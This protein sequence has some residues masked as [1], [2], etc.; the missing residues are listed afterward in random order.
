MY[1]KWSIIDYNRI[2][3]WALLKVNNHPKSKTQ[4]S[5]LP[6]RAR[7]QISVYSHY[8]K[9]VYSR[10]GVVLYWSSLLVVSFTAIVQGHTL[11][12]LKHRSPRA[13]RN[14]IALG[15]CLEIEYSASPRALF[16]VVAKFYTKWPF[17]K[18]CL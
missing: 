18:I 7:V 11:N 16:A 9:S 4:R 8:E 10:N 15:L 17:V 13:L 14:I 3:I 5:L 1:N 2:Y 6:G 12:Q